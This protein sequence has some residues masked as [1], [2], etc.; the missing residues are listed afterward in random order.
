M[1][2]TTS[3]TTTSRASSTKAPID[4]S[5]RIWCGVS[6]S[7]PIGMIVS[8]A[9]ATATTAA[10]RHTN[11]IAG[12]SRWRHDHQAPAVSS[13]PSTTSPA[14]A[15]PTPG[16][17]TGSIVTPSG[18]Y[19]VKGTA[20]TNELRPHHGGNASSPPAMRTAVRA[21]TVGSS[22][23]MLLTIRA[24]LPWPAPNSCSTRGCA[25]STRTAPSDQAPLRRRRR[26]SPGRVAGSSRQRRRYTTSAPAAA[27]STTAGTIVA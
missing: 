23:P 8:D 26:T 7:G 1:C 24:M 13:T 16:R 17:P 22:L 14:R 12:R 10:A 9:R 27:T 6:P 19:G 21:P 3:S 11:V 4:Q 2:F 20:S 25:H 15:V 18:P 5:Q